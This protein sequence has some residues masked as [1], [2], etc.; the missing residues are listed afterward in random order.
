M[1]GYTKCYYN[2]TKIVK[3]HLKGRD[4]Y[5]DLQPVFFY[6]AEEWHLKIMNRAYNMLL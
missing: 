4:N 6:R 2:N 3:S 5:F 1:Q